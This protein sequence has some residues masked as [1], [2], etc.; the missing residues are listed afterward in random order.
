MVDKKFDDGKNVADALLK[1]ERMLEVAVNN[2]NMSSLRQEIKV[3]VRRSAHDCIHVDISDFNRIYDN[4]P[5]KL[6][7]MDIADMYTILFRLAAGDDIR[8]VRADAI[9]FIEG[10]EIK[11]W[12]PAKEDY[13]KMKEGL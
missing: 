12:L 13:E 4:A 9:K 1:A 5:A 3:F 11:H 7:W 10:K 6:D 2:L 8:R